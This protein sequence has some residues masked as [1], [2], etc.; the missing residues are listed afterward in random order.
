M[1]RIPRNLS[2]SIYH[3]VIVQGINKSYIFDNRNDILHYIK[4][5]RQSAAECNIELISYCVM[6]NHS[7]MLTKTENIEQLTK[8]M[9]KVN[10]KYAMYYNNIHSYHSIFEIKYAIKV[11]F[12]Q[13]IK[14]QHM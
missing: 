13:L 2:N 9:R 4:I 12:Y 5:L 8:Y 14:C 6:S 10:T 1:S 7:H 3:H 11:N